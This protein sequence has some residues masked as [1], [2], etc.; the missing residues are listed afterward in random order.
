MKIRLK[1]IAQQTGFSIN[2]VSRALKDKDDISEETKKIILS[3]AEEMGYIPNGVASGLRSG[4]TNTIAVVLSDVS[5]P[6]FSI[7]ARFIEIAARKKGYAIFVLNSGE[8]QEVEE[9][10][11]YLALQKGVDGIILFPAQQSANSIKILEKSGIP[12]ILVGRHFPGLNTNYLITDDVKGG[13]LATKYLIDRGAE[14]ILLLN[15]PEYVSCSTEREEGYRR[16]L[17]ESGIGYDP[18]LVV[19]HD[20]TQGNSYHIMNG[21]LERNVRFQAIFA[22]NDMVAWEAIS[23]LEEKGIKVPGD[24]NV[25]GYDNIQSHL[26]IPFPLTSIDICKEEMAYRAIEILVKKIQGKSKKKIY[27]EVFPTK[28]VVRS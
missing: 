5:N 26:F 17:E 11:V 16:A 19:R 14:K 28:L 13:Y 20:V 6:Y 2:T 22:F 1:D 12:F 24:M 23:A 3:A 15:A 9:K 25:V 8:K 18:A 7:M 10:S 21:I 4:M 27:R